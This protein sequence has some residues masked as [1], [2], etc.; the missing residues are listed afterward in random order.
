M[1]RFLFSI[2]M[3]VSSVIFGATMHAQIK[4]QSGKLTIG[5]TDPFQ[6]Y[7]ITIA[8][9]G[10][11]FNHTNNRYL[12]ISVAATGA[13]RIAG[14][15]DQIVFYNSQTSVFNSIQVSKVYNYSDARAKTNVVT[16]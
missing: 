5:D 8:G 15:N 16:Q 9:N 12:Q 11:Y 3:L 4:F 2:M 10:V 7:G 14:H 6:Y 1:K 13:P